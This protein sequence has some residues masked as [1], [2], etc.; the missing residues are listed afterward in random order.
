MKIS[1]RFGMI[2]LVLLPLVLAWGC[3][4]PTPPSD[5]TVPEALLPC[6]SIAD[7]NAQ[8][9]LDTWDCSVPAPCPTAEFLDQ[10]A[11][12]SGEMPHFKDVAAAKCILEK[13]RDRTISTVSYRYEYGFIPGQYR[14]DETIFIVDA[15][16][17]LSNSSQLADLGA[18]GQ[19]QNRAIL[20]PASKFE[21]CLKSTDES[22]IMYCIRGWASG[23]AE[24]AVKCPE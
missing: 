22:A 19:T 12:P 10:D 7:F 24:V 17:G 4:A 11:V 20:A 15:E 13:L 6:T 5:E 8:E 18:I 16:H 21:E 14:T 2:A 23:C 3:S 1:T 9:M